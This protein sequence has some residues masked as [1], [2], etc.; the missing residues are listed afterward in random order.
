MS[1]ELWSVKW[2]DPMESSRK[3][4]D[5]NLH[6]ATQLLSLSKAFATNHLLGRGKSQ[7]E[8]GAGRGFRDSQG[9]VGSSH[10][11]A[12]RP[13]RTLNPWE[14]GAAAI[15]I[16]SVS[17]KPEVGGGPGRQIGP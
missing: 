12:A 11:S 4:L 16:S 10:I 13:N 2:F 7:V 8:R 17:D 14:C 3:V 9:S 1:T 6:R 5:S 15:S